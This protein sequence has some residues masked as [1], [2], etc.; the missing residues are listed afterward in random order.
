MIVKELDSVLLR[1]YVH[2]RWLD[3]WA[4]MSTLWEI[5]KD[6]RDFFGIACTKADMLEVD[7][8]CPVIN[9]LEGVVR[10][11]VGGMTPVRYDI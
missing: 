8:R 11:I 5:F 7:G 6:F 9:S 3:P 2:M 4:I 1:N 10:N